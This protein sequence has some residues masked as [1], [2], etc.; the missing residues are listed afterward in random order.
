MKLSVIVPVY[1]SPKTLEELVQR[2]STS[3][4]SLA[5]DK[6]EVI[7]VNDACPKGSWEVIKALVNNNT[8]IKGINLSRNFGQHY[9]I[10]AGLEASTGSWTIVMD[11]D[12]QDVPEEIVNLYNK[13]SEGYDIVFAS[14]V[15]RED[16]F[17][18][19]L[20]SSVFYKTLSY[21]TNTKQNAAI[22][23]FGIYSRKVIDALLEFREQ[24]RFF[25]VN[26]RWLGFRSYELDVRHSSRAEGTSSY[27]LR[28]LIYLATGIIFS[29]SNKPMALLVNIGAIIAT[30]SVFTALGLVIKYFTQSVTVPGWTGIMVS[31]W[32][33]FGCIL[34][35]LGIIG[36]YVG[37]AFDESKRRPLYIV[38]DIIVSSEGSK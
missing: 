3:V 38:K 16:N 27:S 19:K 36:I 34:F 1:G 18:K 11:C 35:A 12:L 13:A 7:L 5:I 37:K 17:F 20:G 23:N 32:F 8:N 9:A 14:R 21:A 24:L 31:L 4:K 6:Y 33:M 30:I 28:K 29:F 26:I 22:A 10:L 15:Q 25:P 2:V